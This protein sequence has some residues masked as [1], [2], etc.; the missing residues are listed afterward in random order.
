[1]GNLS[2]HFNYSAFTCKCENCRGKG[3]FQIHL[4]LIGGLE[5]L[6]SSLKKPVKVETGFR[7]DEASE[8]VLGSKKSYHTQ[9]KAANIIAEEVSLSQL[10]KAAEQIP[11]FKGIGFYPGENFV[12]VDTRAGDREEWVKETGK[13]APLTREKRR[14]YDLG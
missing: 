8:K 3:E 4:G 7:C 2:E 10:F 14:Q 6:V 9:G 13:Y 5:L 11:E 12:H 1:M